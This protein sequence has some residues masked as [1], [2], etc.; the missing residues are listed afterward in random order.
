VKPNGLSQLSQTFRQS[1]PLWLRWCSIV[2]LLASVGLL[3]IS[4]FAYSFHSLSGAGLVPS[5]LVALIFATF[6]NVY[7]LWRFRNEHREADQAFRDTDC[8]AS[9]IFRNV[10]DGILIANNEGNCL[11]ANPAAAGILRCSPNE[12]IGQNIGRFLADA[13]AFAQRWNS[14]LQNKNQ[15]GRARLVARDGTP[16]Y[17]DFTATA[18]YL[19]GRHLLILCDVTER[20]HA[21]LS[22]RRSEERFQHMANNIQEIFWMLDAKTQ[23]VAYVNHA[24]VTITGHSV[25]SLRQNPTS[26][27]EVI[28]PEDRIRVLSKLADVADFG[29]FDEEFRFIR[30]DGEVR[31]GWA[32]GFPVSTDGE[33]RWL[34]GTAQDITSRK[35]A[36]TKISEHLDAAEAA[37]AE[38]EALRKSTLALSQNLAMDSVLDTLLQCISELVPFDVAT[39]LFVEDALHLMV[40]REAPRVMPKRIGLTFKAAEDVFLEKIL[41]EQRAVLLRDVAQEREWRGVRPL[42][43]I[44]SWLGVPLIAAGDVLGI[45]SLGADAPNVFASEHL[46]LAKSLAVAAA[47]AIKNARDHERAEIYAAELQVR[48]M[49]I[50]TER[51][52]ACGRPSKKSGAPS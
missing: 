36:E 37:R 18:N 31:W 14:F 3:C 24:Y 49:E 46:R 10:L 26:Y 2:T 25:E 7:S 39:V 15:R 19:P 17:V 27:R 22:L 45:L 32:K 4:L 38:A 6:L 42:D 8:E 47:V 9:S 44:G 20:T 35:Q 29:T 23:E 1:S 5:L 30:A 12:L 48:L 43:R 13:D 28:H 52:N 40:A 51:Q 34:V 11:D 50:D 33:T 16:L 21:E 41:F